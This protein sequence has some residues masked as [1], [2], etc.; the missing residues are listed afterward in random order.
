MI[1]GDRVKIKGFKK[2]IFEY[3]GNIN[4]WLNPDESR[5]L[6]YILKTVDTNSIIQATWDEIIK[7]KND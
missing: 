3:T 4:T 2:R 6:Y 5:Q 7:I 1:K